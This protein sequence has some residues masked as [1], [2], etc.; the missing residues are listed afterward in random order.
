MAISGHVMNLSILAAV[1]VVSC[2]EPEWCSQD[3]DARLLQCP[4]FS[5]TRPSDT[6]HFN[7]T[8]PPFRDQPA[9]RHSGTHTCWP[10]GS[11]M[12]CILGNLLN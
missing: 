6:V 3:L 4:F 7:R 8:V 12:R 1:V 10:S 5:N 11:R 9:S 2:A